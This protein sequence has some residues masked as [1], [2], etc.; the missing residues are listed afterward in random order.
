MLSSP[1]ESPTQGYPSWDDH[2]STLHSAGCEDKKFGNSCPLP[3]ISPYSPPKKASQALE[4]AP[5]NNTQQMLAEFHQ[6]ISTSPI[7]LPLFSKAP[8]VFCYLRNTALLKSSERT[9][10]I[11]EATS[12]K[13]GVNLIK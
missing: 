12:S 3:G 7:A 13:N 10:N 6:P 2:R 4:I 1:S 8:M 9:I 5:D 11:S